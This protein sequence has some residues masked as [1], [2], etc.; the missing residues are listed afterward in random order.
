MY[1]YDYIFSDCDNNYLIA[2]SL[3]SMIYQLVQN[4]KNILFLTL[5][6]ND[7]GSSK[8][9]FD[10]SPG[11]LLGKNSFFNYSFQTI[12]QIM[13]KD[14]Q[15]ENILVEIYK[16]TNNKFIIEYVRIKYLK[17]FREK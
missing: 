12:Y 13:N 7:L 4:Q 16:I 14:K 5:G 11:Y 17:I 10:N 3:S 15:Y 6:Q 9:I 8:F 2:N 1:K